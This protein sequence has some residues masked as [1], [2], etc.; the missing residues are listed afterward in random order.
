MK[1]QHKGFTLIELLVVVAIIMIL[2]A[3]ILASLGGA[4]AKARGARA[5]S[6][7]SSMRAAAELYYSTYGSYADPS[8]ALFSDSASG[9]ANLVTSVTNTAGGV[10]NTVQLATNDTWAF[11]AL[12]GGT[13]YCADSNGFSGVGIAVDMGSGSG[14]VYQCQP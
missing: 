1:L 14:S 9:M 7:I 12:V 4:R 13:N 5:S 3:T 10:N 11:S 6:E 2:A 8:G